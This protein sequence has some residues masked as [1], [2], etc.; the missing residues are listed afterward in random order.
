MPNVRAY[1]G[2]SDQQ[3]AKAIIRLQKESDSVY[4]TQTIGTQSYTKNMDR[5][6]RQLAAAM[7]VWQERGG[8]SMPESETDE[9]GGQSRQ[10][11]NGG[12]DYGDVRIS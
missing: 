12:T 5:I 3:L 10:P 8:T 9:P 7:E 2:Y 6:D 1:R 4:E 11:Y